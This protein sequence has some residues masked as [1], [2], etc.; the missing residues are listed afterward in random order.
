MMGSQKSTKMTAEEFEKMYKS[1]GEINKKQ[2]TLYPRISEIES[3][4]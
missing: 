4:R 2:G 1:K 3:T